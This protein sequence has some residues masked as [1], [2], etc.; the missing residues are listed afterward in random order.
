MAV[1]N[2]TGADIF[3]MLP[4]NCIAN[5]LSMTTPKDACRLS[6][7]ASNFHSAAQFDAVW[8]R[9]LP[10]DYRDL[11][12]RATNAGD[13]LAFTSKKDLY[14]YLCDHPVIIDCGA[15]SFSLDKTSGK[16]CY[17]LAA[18]SLDIAWGN[19]ARYWRCLSLPGSRFS[20]VNEL[21][22]VWWFEIRGKISTKMLS[23]D[24]NYA[25]YL[26]FRVRANIYGFESQPVDA[27]VRIIGQEAVTRIVYLDPKKVLV[28]PRTKLG[29]WELDPDEAERSWRMGQLG[30][31][32][33]G[34]N[35][36]PPPDGE[37]PKGR[38]DKWMEVEL[39]EIFIRGS[40]EE[41]WVEISL[42]EVHGGQPKGGI[43]V[44]GIEIRPK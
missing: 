2:V 10:P 16:K 26:V 33:T 17:M 32:Q 4:E 24:T 8:E 40:E 20:E 11:V 36:N 43:I 12:S 5:A 23:P 25:A 31:R 44:Q 34:Q 42:M 27:L 9:F 15:K 39:G 19:D 37:H 30:H 14:F 21:L 29:P 22:H 38:G 1:E 28:R 7:V 3:A 35:A 41:D 13:L 6:L 18:R